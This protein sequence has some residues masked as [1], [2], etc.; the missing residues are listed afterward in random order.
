MKIIIAP[1]SFKGALSAEKVAGAFAD[2]WRQVRGDADEVIILPLSDGGEGMA[3]ALCTACGGEYITLRSHD[4]LRREISA[5]AVIAG[6]LAIVESAAANGIELLKSGELN[7]FAATTFGVGEI[8]Q[9][10]YDAGFR[11]YLI[12]IGGSATVDGG[13]GMLQALGVR[14]TDRNG[15]ILPDGIGGGTLNDAAAVSG[16]DA[17][18]KWHRCRIR[19]A[20]DVT[21]VL[22]GEN[23]SARVFGPQ[24]GASGDM[25]YALDENLRHWAELLGD[26]GMFP[27][28]GAAGGLGFALRHVLHAEMVSGAEAVMRHSGFYD[29]LAG[30]DLVITGEGCSDAQSICG[31]LCCC[32]AKAAKKQDVPV[33]LFSGA[34]KGDIPELEELF[35]GCF[36]IACGPG[37]LADAIAATEP[38]LRRAGAN[39]ARIANLFVMK[40]H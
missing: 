18:A 15:N 37:T 38:N 10:L 19:V 11:K 6:D 32:V 16:L 20:C 2:G 29:L 8:L 4:A 24:K 22:C 40:K 34:L 14:I 13:A 17:L 25:V 23:G 30:A 21:N 27:G 5:R 31:K 12:G 33:M 39:L 36:S 35:D 26:P 3:A 9:Q 7:P 28:D 1:D